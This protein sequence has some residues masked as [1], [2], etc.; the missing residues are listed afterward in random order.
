MEN[1]MHLA[2]GMVSGCTGTLIIQPIDMV[3]VRLQIKNEEIGLLRSQGKE[4]PKVKLGFFPM[5]K[6]IM[7]ESGFLGLYKGLSSAL[8]RQVFYATTRLGLYKI[9]TESHKKKHNLEVIPAYW[10]VVYGIT[11][12]FLGCLAGNPADL[13][14]VR[15]QSDNQ[16]PAAQR[17]NYTGFWNAIGRIIKDEGVMTLWRGST[18]TVARGTTITVVMLASYDEIKERLS[19]ILKVHQENLGL[20]VVGSLI[21]GTLAAFCALPF[22]NAKT[23]LQKMKANPD[24]TMPYKNIFDAIIKTATREGV[25]GLWIGLPVFY[26]RVGPHAMITLLVQD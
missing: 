20:R 8:M 9:L 4:I 1:L 10:K 11:S 21:A 2:I 26:S 17:R 14:L 25:T 24:G 6:T 22:D 19:K 12:G 23:K 13:C 3:K 5:T 18:P 7:N 16:L 15:I